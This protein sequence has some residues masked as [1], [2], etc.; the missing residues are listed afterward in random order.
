M[1]GEKS[2]EVVAICCC[3]QQPEFAY[4]RQIVVPGTY[5]GYGYVLDRFV[6]CN[7][8]RRA[9]HE[10]WKQSSRSGAVRPDRCHR[11]RFVYQL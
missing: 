11:S 1:R 4:L 3:I 9:L 6:A 5:H 10:P 8:N 2:I 7:I